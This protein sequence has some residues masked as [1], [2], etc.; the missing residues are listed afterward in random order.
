MDE[1]ARGFEK[2]VHKTSSIF[3]S[4]AACL[5]FLLMIA[6]PADV[7]GRYLLNAPINGTMER[8]QLILAL[9]V[10]LSWGHTQLKRGHVSVELF[11]SRFPTRLR[12]LSEIVTTLITLFMFIL[13]PNLPE[14]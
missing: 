4:V 13:V 12:I 14:A 9:M 3:N 11:I 5:L 10:F 1:D 2:I 6:G 8:G 7:L